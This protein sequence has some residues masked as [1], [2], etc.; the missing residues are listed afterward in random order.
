MKVVQYLFQKKK[1]SFYK[2]PYNYHNNSYNT[3]FLN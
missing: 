2:I 3:I 1:N